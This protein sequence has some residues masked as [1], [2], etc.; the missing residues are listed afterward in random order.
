MKI[1]ILPGATSV[2]DGQ[3]KVGWLCPY[4][5]FDGIRQKLYDKAKWQATYSK[6]ILNYKE[7]SDKALLH[8]VPMYLKFIE[9]ILKIEKASQAILIPVPSSKPKSSPKYSAKPYSFLNKKNRDD[10][11]LV[12]CKNLEQ[13][14]K[15]LRCV[16]LIERVQEKPEKAHWGPDEHFKSMRLNPTYSEKLAQGLPYILID[17]VLTKGGTLAGAKLLLQQR[18][19]EDL[20]VLTAIGKTSWEL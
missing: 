1:D 17:D 19:P 16:E 20:V 18:V 8:F 4:F 15:G 14:G 2:Y 7:G 11:N 5:P 3:N 9:W 13:A 12:F 6:E 10:R